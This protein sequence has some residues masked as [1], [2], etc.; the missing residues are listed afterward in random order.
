MAVEV[1]ASS[2][3]RGVPAALDTVPGHKFVLENDLM[4]VCRVSI[5]PKQSTGVR[6]RTLPWLRISVSQSTISVQEQ[7]KPSETLE[8]K[9]GDYRWH[10][11]VTA[12]SLE[13]IGSAPTRQ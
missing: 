2:T 7:G 13:N 1:K 9:P 12:Q 4:K 6:S 5:D 10:E 11:G 3:S 8:T